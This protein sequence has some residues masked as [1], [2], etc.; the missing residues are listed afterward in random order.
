MDT[1]DS[2][3][4]GVSLYS[5]KATYNIKQDKQ[6]MENIQPSKTYMRLN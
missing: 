6:A 4:Q 2:S 3:G 1:T 5:R